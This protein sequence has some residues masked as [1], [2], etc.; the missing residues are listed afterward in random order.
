MHD[1]PVLL[2][3]I[4]LSKLYFSHGTQ[5]V[6]FQDINLS[7]FKGEI[8][9][10]VGES[11]SGK[12]TLGKCLLHLIPPSHG[13]VFFDKLNLDTLR[14]QEKRK[15]CK[16]MQIVFQNPTASLNPLMTVKDII[17]EGLKIH[18]LSTDAVDYYLHAVEL[19]TS[20]LNRYPHQLSGGQCQRVAIARALVLKPD[21]IVFDEALSA[22]DVVTRLQLLSMLK[23]LKDE[24]NLTYLFITHDLQ[25]LEG[26]A[27]RVAV[28]H[29]GNIVEIATPEH[30]LQNP[31][32][33]YTKILVAS[34]PGKKHLKNYNRKVLKEYEIATQMKS[35]SLLVRS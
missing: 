5:H 35:G 20:F 3:S 17:T 31:S 18:K 1:K 33:P 16:R 28:M 7:I 11:G 19:D 21:F 6:A 9:A 2:Q 22:L 24:F 32:D 14:I 34:I 8:L 13:T 15:L 23:R 27:N 26:F 12:S 25:T 10:L 29:R 30:I 4:N